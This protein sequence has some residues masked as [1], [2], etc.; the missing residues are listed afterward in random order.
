MSKDIVER[1]REYDASDKKGSGVYPPEGLISDS[2]EEIE[3]L[4]ENHIMLLERM[5]IFV[6][7]VFYA[8]TIEGNS[9]VWLHDFL[10]NKPYATREFEAWLKWTEIEQ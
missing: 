1:L 3:R 4:R 8:M 10:D 7:A 6:N 9:L 5:D 2:I